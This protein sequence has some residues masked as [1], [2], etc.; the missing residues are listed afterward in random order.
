LFYKKDAVCSTL[1]AIKVVSKREGSTV[2][3]SYN[4]K[5][6]DSKP[7]VNGEAVFLNLMTGS[8]SVTIGADYKVIVINLKVK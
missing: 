6:M 4:G 3:L 5:L 2:Q 7:V 8:Y 1:G